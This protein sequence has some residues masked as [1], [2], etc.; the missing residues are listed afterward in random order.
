MTTQIYPIKVSK[1]GFKN[2]CYLIIHTK[3][4]EAV[5][6]DPAWEL[7]KIEEVI[8]FH[9]VKLTAIL[10]THHHFDHINLAE[11]LAR[12]YQIPVLMS[13]IESDYY[14]F[15]CYNLTYIEQLETIAFNHIKITPI[16][17]PGHTKGALSYWI[18]KALF[19]GDTLFIEGCGICTGRGGD[20]EAMF[21]SLAYLK[22][23][24]LPETKIYPG[25]SFGQEPGK[26]FAYVAQNN[27]YLQF[28]NCED[29][30]A[31]RMRKN[32]KGLLAF[33]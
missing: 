13:K 23:T 24:L 5:L 4:R 32:Q 3:T 15:S 1:L 8:A 2:Y 6:I 16:L 26:A 31:F 7:D 14:H 33:R 17:T 20:P 30:V 21:E 10:L 18:D 9:Q 25:H 11:P 22:D 27:I 19:T 29:F 28:T 12:R